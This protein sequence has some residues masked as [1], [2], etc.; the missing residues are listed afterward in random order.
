LELPVS[1]FLATCST[2]SSQEAILWLIGS[3]GDDSPKSPTVKKLLVPKRI[4]DQR[5]PS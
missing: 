2:G 5:K 4:A 3:Q 1:R